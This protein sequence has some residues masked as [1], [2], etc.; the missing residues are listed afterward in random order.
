MGQF[1]TILL[2]ILL[3][4]M[5]IC[6]HS[7]RIF[8]VCS[9]NQRRGNDNETEDV[10]IVATPKKFHKVDKELIT[11]VLFRLCDHPFVSPSQLFPMG[12]LLDIN[13]Q[14][15]V[16]LSLTFGQIILRR[17]DVIKNHSQ[18]GDDQTNEVYNCWRL[19]IIATKPTN[20][21]NLHH[22]KRNR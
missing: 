12:E 10:G 2:P 6:K 15:S 18:N 22:R 21:Y 1:N 14:K 7:F 11:P 17:L 20:H 13:H 5:V 3:Y 19:S 4:I 8:L 9:T 16:I